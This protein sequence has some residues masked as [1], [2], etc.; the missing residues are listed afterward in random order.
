M[1]FS[2][3]YETI[4]EMY[5]PHKTRGNVYGFFIQ[6]KIASGLLIECV[7]SCK[8]DSDYRGKVITYE[9]LFCRNDDIVNRKLVGG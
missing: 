8:D 7:F 5:G 2:C 4:V 6:W 3:D 9:T 1:R